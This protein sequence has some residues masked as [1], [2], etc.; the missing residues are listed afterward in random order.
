MTF[1]TKITIDNCSNFE[2]N[3]FRNTAVN[4]LWHSSHVFRDGD[5]ASWSG[6]MQTYMTGDHP[7][8]AQV[9]LLP[10][11]NLKPTD[12]TCI[13]STLLFVRSLS[14]RYKMGTAC[15][16]FNQPLWLKSVEIIQSKSLNMVCRLGGFHTIMSFLGSIG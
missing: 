15:I 13:Y 11:I 12:E 1:D 3:V 16:T 5:Q 14:E 10:T 9:L 8:K 6:F 4:L 7:G 2:E